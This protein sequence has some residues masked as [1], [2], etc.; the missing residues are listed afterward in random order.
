MLVFSIVLLVVKVHKGLA[1]NPAPSHWTHYL[2]MQTT[3]NN[4]LVM[5]CFN[6]WV[7]SG[8]I[9]SPVTCQH[10]IVNSVSKGML[11][12]NQVC[13]HIDQSGSLL[14]GPIMSG[15]LATIQTVA[16]TDETFLPW[17]SPYHSSH[18]IGMSV[19][20]VHPC[21]SHSRDTQIIHV[22]V[23]KSLI[24]FQIMQHAQNKSCKWLT[25][26][27]TTDIKKYIL[28]L[29]NSTATLCTLRLIPI[30]RI[31]AKKAAQLQSKPADP[32]IP[33]SS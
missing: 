27:R 10:F 8:S 20:G 26:Q 5:T 18:W 2:L 32:L 6:L 31:M 16:S 24:V 3:L 33:C 11:L 9:N 15:K 4:G 30:S 14:Y 1:P 7:T 23:F 22:S 13:C 29:I 12:T 19:S 28:P 21:C 17:G 25:A